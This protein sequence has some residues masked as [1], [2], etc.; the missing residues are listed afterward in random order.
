MYIVYVLVLK[1]IP[2]Y[3][4]GSYISLSH[5]YRI[6]LRFRI[7]MYIHIYISNPPV[8][9]KS[10]YPWLI[11]C[12]R[13]V[14]PTLQSTPICNRF[15]YLRHGTE[16]WPCGVVTEDVHRVP[17]SP[18]VDKGVKVGNNKHQLIMTIHRNP[19][20]CWQNQRLYDLGPTVKALKSS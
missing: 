18:S 1:V 6:C 12:K 10:F 19:L 16:A 14:L 15:V 5:V 17:L 8:L 7:H 9:N 3:K 2:C 20:N 11:V 13:N 4:I